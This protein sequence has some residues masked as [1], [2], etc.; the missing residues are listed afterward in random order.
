[1][2]KHDNK[3][4]RLRRKRWDHLLNNERDAESVAEGAA[5]LHPA[6]QR[7]MPAPRKRKG[8]RNLTGYNFGNLTHL[9][10]WVGS[11]DICQFQIM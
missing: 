5:E 9:P 4:Q 1:M 8:K 7:L 3:W 2:R 6:T 11:I 10:Y